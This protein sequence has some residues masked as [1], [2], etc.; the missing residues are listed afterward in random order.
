M[1]E[2]FGITRAEAELGDPNYVRDAPVVTPTIDEETAD[3]ALPPTSSSTGVFLEQDGN[4][5]YTGFGI[6]VFYN[7]TSGLGCAPKAGPKGT[8]LAFWRCHGGMATLRINWV[9]KTVGDRPVCPHP[10]SLVNNFVLM[11]MN[12]HQP[13]VIY[14]SNSDPMWFVSGSY[15]YVAQIPLNHSDPIPSTT[16]PRINVPPHTHS[17]RVSD[18]TTEFIHSVN[19]SGTSP[20]NINY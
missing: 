7:T 19:P 20:A 1:P 10:D 14:T 9:A 11:E 2:F 8:S 18:F 6:E 12:I 4:R 5:I 13:A 17:L 3:P 15:S 16:V